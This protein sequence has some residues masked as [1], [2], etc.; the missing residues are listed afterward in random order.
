MNFSTN[1]S[2]KDLVLD[3][4]KAIKWYCRD[5]NWIGFKFPGSF[6]SEFKRLFHFPLSESVAIIYIALLF[7]IVRYLFEFFLCKVIDDL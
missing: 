6:I 5:D 3:T 2:Y 4:Y 1:P 7:T